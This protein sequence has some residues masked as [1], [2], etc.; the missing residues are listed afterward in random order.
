MKKYMRYIL[1]FVAFFFVFSD[2]F[3]AGCK[4]AVKNELASLANYVK[5]NYE[6][7]EES[8]EREI[9]IDGQSTTYKI[10]KYV[11]EITIYNL[12]EGLAASVSAL[13][14]GRTFK[15][16]NSDTTDNNYTFYDYDIGQ[17]YNYEIS[18]VSDRNDCTSTRLRT[19]KFTKPR[20]N[21]YSEFTYCQNSSIYY[22]QRF[23][24]S[25]INLKGTDDFL[26]KIKV[27]NDKNNPNRD[28][29]E[30]KEEIKSL[31]SKNWKTYVLLFVVIALLIVGIIFY[32][33]R[34]HKKSG[35][36]L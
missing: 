4:P 24:G 29:I 34:R 13:D 6:I 3:A 33:K 22:C 14:Q 23:I 20:Y 35:W 15:V 8:E 16:T 21:A 36:K 28:K 9:T 19:I 17:I 12:K 11:F 1:L 5:V 30:E 10:P 7:K 18:I 26:N 32:I 27:N 31:L 25:E 2:V